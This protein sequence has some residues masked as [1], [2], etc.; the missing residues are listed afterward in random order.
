MSAPFAFVPRKIARA[1]KPAPT[2]AS[3]STTTL[4]VD[5][6][7]KC[8]ETRPAPPKSQYSEEDYTVFLCLSLSKYRLWSDPDLRRDIEWSSRARSNDGF[9]PLGYIIDSPC[10]LA[11]TRASETVIVKALRA[12]ATDI[13]DVR[14]AIPSS[15]AE[16]RGNFEIR[17]KFW[18]DAVYP[19]SREGWENR[20]V[21]VE[22]I[23]IKCK[24]L[25]GLSRF[26]LAL[27]PVNTTM[28]AH[29]RIQG[30]TVPPHHADAPGIE[31]KL[32]SFALIVFASAEDADALL[33]TWPW[34]R[35]QNRNENSTDAS[36]AVKFGFRALPKARWD[37]LN[38]QYLSYRATLLA[39]IEDTEAA[40]APLPAQEH[41]EPVR[42]PAPPA[43]IA[44]PTTFTSYPQNCLI[45]VRNIHP[46]TN[47]TTLRN[48]FATAIEAKEAIDYVDFN[49]GMDSCYL[50]LT[51]ALHA[52][53]LVGHFEQNRTVQASGLDEAGCRGSDNCVEAELVLGKRE[54]VY[55]EKV[56]EKV[57]LQAVQKALEGAH[58]VQSDADDGEG[59]S[60]RKRQKQKR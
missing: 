2:S 26:I 40:E 6:K 33:A 48:F 36:E 54:E 8:R 29:N 13:V 46:E 34:A 18:D 41:P 42:H 20:T 22:N 47:K 27:L 55:W 59:R 39:D 24:T 45:F 60:R 50:R 37:E 49:K 15:S 9:F 12:H 58:P 17:P 35:L 4:P 57:C 31:P 11:S 3:T 7:G 56:P 44:A 43:A 32:K 14:M 23:P 52:K 28:A 21:Y 30:I 16:T 53:S 10:P 5:V 38:A 25:P 1:L 51:T 19:V